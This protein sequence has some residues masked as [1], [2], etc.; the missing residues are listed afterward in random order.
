MKRR[1]EKGEEGKRKAVK[2]SRKCGGAQT[3]QTL[4]RP[5]RNVPVPGE[6]N[7][8]EHLLEI[9]ERQEAAEVVVVVELA[10]E[11]RP[12]DIPTQVARHLLGQSSGLVDELG[13]LDLDFP[14]AHRDAG[15]SESVRGSLVGAG[16]AGDVGVRVP[17]YKFIW[18][19]MILAT[20]CDAVGLCLSSHCQVPARGSRSG[21]PVRPGS[22]SVPC[23]CVI[24]TQHPD[25]T[26][27]FVLDLPV[28]I[29]PDVL[30]LRPS[31]PQT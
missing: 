31:K 12:V 8:G 29:R 24:E 21:R 4:L 7:G 14:L 18:S 9:I 20:C 27:M 23:P 26:P 11:L 28:L 15:R 10:N 1:K 22:P 13:E 25:V 5:V 6:D 19:A 2:E 30:E 17:V 16:T 3:Y